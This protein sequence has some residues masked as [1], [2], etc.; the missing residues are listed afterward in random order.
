MAEVY[1]WILR[2]Y[3]EKTAEDKKEAMKGH[4]SLIDVDEEIAIDAA[5]IKHRLKW[6][7]G[8]SIIYATARREAARVLTGDSDFLG[9]DD[10]IFLNR[11]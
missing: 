6:G 5:R 7:L 2:Y 1:R 8:D 4:C 3:D 9:H 11:T 10:V